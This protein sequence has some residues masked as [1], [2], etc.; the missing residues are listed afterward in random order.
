MLPTLSTLM[1]R[2]RQRRR[3]WRNPPL[4]CLTK[5]KRRSVRPIMHW[6]MFDL[7]TQS[8]PPFSAL[9][10]IFKLM[11]MDSY[12]RFVRS[13]LY[14]SCTL[15]GVEGKLPPQPGR[16]APWDDVAAGNRSLGNKKVARSLR[17]CSRVWGNR[18]LNYEVNTAGLAGNT[19]RYFRP[20]LN[21]GKCT[22]IS[23]RSSLVF[24]F[25]LRNWS[26]NGS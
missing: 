8:V 23:A 20:N 25:L 12:R 22:P 6:C 4:T 15:A 24:L 11:K 26:Q 19:L 5:L 17:E 13:P 3:T 9:C 16:M 21:V 18:N 14:Q 2:L 10:Q 1:T 7:Q